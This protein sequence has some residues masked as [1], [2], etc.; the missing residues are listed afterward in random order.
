MKHLILC[1]LAVFLVCDPSD[2]VLS[3]LIDDNGQVMEVAAQ[4]DGSLKVELDSWPD[5]LHQLQVK[6]KNMWDESDPVPFFFIK[7]KPASPSSLGLIAD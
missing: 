7:G 5:G 4:P 2:G 6:A 3:Y 1:I